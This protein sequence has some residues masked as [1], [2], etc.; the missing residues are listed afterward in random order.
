[1]VERAEPSTTAY[2]LACEECSYVWLPAS[3]R[4][5]MYLTDDYPPLALAYCPECARREFR[6]PAPPADDR[7]VA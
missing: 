3:E 4:W 2:T 5:R 7:N 6:R 1:M